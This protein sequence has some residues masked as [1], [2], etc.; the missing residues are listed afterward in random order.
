MT[1]QALLFDRRQYNG[2]TARQ[3][4][5]AHGYTP[6][7]PVHLT[8]NF[9]RLR[10][11]EPRPAARYRMVSLTPHVRAVTMGSGARL[12]SLAPMMRRGRARGGFLSPETI[13]RGLDLLANLIIPGAIYAGASYGIY[14]AVKSGK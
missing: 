3:W 10:I 11:A 1:T 2:A 7:K 9:A 6:I 13:N 14:K 4:A 12:G 5:R 8:K